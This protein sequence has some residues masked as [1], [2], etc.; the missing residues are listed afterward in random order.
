VLG[1]PRG[2]EVLDVSQAEACARPNIYAFESEPL[3]KPPGFREYDARWLLGS[4]INLMGVE[5]LSMGLGT[6]ILRLH[7]AVHCVS[8]LAAVRAGIKSAAH[9]G[10]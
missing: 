4:E 6:L 2:P 5:A 3:V 10:R 1:H 7:T 9:Y 8:P